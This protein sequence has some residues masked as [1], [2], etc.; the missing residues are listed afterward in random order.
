[1]A[2]PWKDMTQEQRDAEFAKFNEKRLKK[3]IESPAKRGTVKALTDKYSDE[4]NKLKKTA[5]ATLPKKVYTQE[6]IAAKVAKYQE[7]LEK[8]AGKAPVKRVATKNL[9]KAHQEEY[10]GMLKAA[11]A[12]VRGQVKPAGKSKR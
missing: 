12:E 1:M 6:E 9:I 11:L 8:G 7:K 4:F 10:D 3:S 5:E 2:T